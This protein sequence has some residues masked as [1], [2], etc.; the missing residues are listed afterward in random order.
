[1]PND[2]CA[3]VTSVML[4]NAQQRVR[5]GQSGRMGRIVNRLGTAPFLTERSRKRR[6]PGLARSRL[7]ISV[8]IQRPHI[9]GVEPFRGGGRII[10]RDIGEMEAQ[11]VALRKIISREDDRA[12]LRLGDRRQAAGGN[13]DGAV[14]DELEIAFDL[15]VDE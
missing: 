11:A 13:V 15:L 1:M 7:L 6:S 3:V 2:S 4:Y 12:G 8:L 5:H 10:A 14:G 9:S